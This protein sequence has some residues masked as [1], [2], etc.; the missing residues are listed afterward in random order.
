ME[1]KTRVS[2]WIF[3]AFFGAWLGGVYALVTQAVNWLFLPGIP[4]APPSGTLASY[5][6]EFILIG[7]LLGWICAIPAHRMAG[8]LLGGLVSALLIS[9]MALRG[10]WGGE[11]F[12]A[13]LI[14]MLLTFMPL[15]VL[16][17]PISLAIR[18]GVDA[19]RVDPARPYLWARRYAIP[20]LLTVLVVILGV[21]ALYSREERSAFQYVQGMIQQS[22]LAASVAA[23]PEPVR[24]IPGFLENSRGA[25]QLSWSDRVDTFFGP[26]PIGSELSQFL[27]IT[28]FENGYSFACVFSENRQI[29]NCAAYD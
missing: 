1:Q 3:G 28:R 5:L 13:T 4:L 15:V 17:L 27:I 24:E 12:S 20:G 6:V 14:L 11:F 22:Q 25:Y 10:T 18:I 29:P 23:L 19:Q 2:T 21:L 26:V 7:A 9:V 16:M 8:V